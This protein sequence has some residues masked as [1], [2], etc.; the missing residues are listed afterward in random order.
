M[1]STFITGVLALPGWNL[2]LLLLLAKATIIL[3]AA[4]GITL[5]MQRTS[6]GARHLVWLVTLGMLLLVPALTVW[7]PLRLAILPATDAPAI[8]QPRAAAPT[9][10]SPPSNQSVPITL[11]APNATGMSPQAEA[12]P[13]V[14]DRLL[15]PLRS[16][17]TLSLVLVL[18]GAVVLGIVTT[19]TWAGLSVRRIV[20]HARTLDSPDWV[21]PLF[22]ISDRLGL[23][24]PPRL[25]QSEEAKMPFAC[26][27]MTPTIVLPADSE[28]WTLDRRRAVLIHELAHVRRHD[29]LGHTLGRLVCAFYWFHPLVWTA[30]KRLRSES[31]R[32]CD[33]LA[34]TCGTRATDYAEHLL[35]IVTSVRGDSTPYVALAMARRKEFEGRMLAILDPELR[36][37]SPSLRQS[38]GLVASLALLSLTVAAARPVARDA[39]PAAPSQHAGSTP[40]A[41]EGSAR[42]TVV[43]DQV[44]RRTLTAHNVVIEQHV[45]IGSSVYAS[46]DA[47]ATAS[48]SPVSPASPSPLPIALPAPARQPADPAD[49]S[50]LIS[51]AAIQ[52]LAKAGANFGANVATSVLGALG[53]AVDTKGAK[54]SKDADDRPILL[55]RVLK[56]DT[57]AS[58][59]RIAAWGLQEYADSPV[60]AEALAAALRHDT[61]AKVREMSAWS[62]GEGSDRSGVTTDALMAA[63][64]GDADERVRATSAWALGNIGDRGAVDALSAALGDASANVRMRAAWAIGN[65]EPKQAPRALIALLSDKDVRTRQL[66]AWALYQIEDPASVPALKAA[67]KAEENKDVQISYIRAIAAMG[68]QSVDAIRDLLESSDPR[69][70]AMA[71]R[72]L[73]GGHASGPW[74]WPWPEPR[75]FP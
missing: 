58:L 46:A 41:R 11:G 52:Q 73:A 9:S 32:A 75:P 26:G 2:S 56:S 40:A 57:S 13:S 51:N 74:P 60:A 48:R 50:H 64:K 21:T 6:A 20:R 54:G 25:V 3:V 27:M 66:A 31:E 10:I 22:E 12:S 28:S 71:V 38:V 1:T 44:A 45:Q 53:Q 43:N 47:G 18:W 19:L 14:M 29:L 7:A 34:L 59:R 39:K 63:L 8:E 35:D 69:V 55:A 67:L 42:D 30:A 49:P 65:S 24:E 70:K 4:L 23:E 16:M 61:D 33:D 72:A 37:S 62:I 17:S 15:A 36:H 68:D 5:A